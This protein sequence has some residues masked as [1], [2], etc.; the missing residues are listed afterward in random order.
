MNGDEIEGPRAARRAGRSSGPIRATLSFLAF[1]G[2]VLA[3]SL[4]IVLPLWS[5]ATRN[6]VAFTMALAGILALGL[7]F[8]LGRA[9]GRARRR[10]GRRLP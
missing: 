3:L 7:L 2:I 8:I 6:R 10:G 5:L 1:A 4:V 9:V